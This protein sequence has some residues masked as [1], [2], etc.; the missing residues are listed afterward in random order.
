MNGRRLAYPAPALAGYPGRG[1]PSSRPAVLWSDEGNAGV[2][3]A[4]G[5]LVATEELRRVVASWQPDDVPG[6]WVKRPDEPAD[7]WNVSLWADSP[8]VPSVEA[9]AHLDECDDEGCLRCNMFRVV[10]TRRR[11]QPPREFRDFDFTGW[12]ALRGELDDQPAVEW[13]VD[14][15][16]VLAVFGRHTAHLWP[17]RIPGLR[18]EVV[19]RLKADGRAEYVFDH[20]HTASKLRPGEVEVT[21][22][23]LWESPRTVLR[24]RYGARGQK[25]H[26]KERVPQPI[27]HSYRSTRRVPDGL[28]GDCKRRA[29]EQWEPVIEQWVGL[30]IPVDVVACNR[31]DGHGHLLARD[32]GEL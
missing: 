18:E 4:D 27:A 1:W 24:D 16:S 9:L 10:Y 8:D 6:P 5:W 14:D 3:V 15:P 28:S 20:P 11:V 23:I 17:G 2:A 32:A 19:R 7:P 13:V 25:L 21:T 26:G 30:F 31:C 22:R 29:V 12:T